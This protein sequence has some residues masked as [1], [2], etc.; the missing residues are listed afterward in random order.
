MINQ[1]Y[2]IFLLTTITANSQTK[3]YGIIKDH[4]GHVLTNATITLKG[5]Y[6]GAVSDPLGKYSFT[7]LEK[8]AYWIEAKSVGYRTETQ[9]II[10]PPKDLLQLNFTLK[11]EIT[12]L[13]AVMVTAGSFAAGDKKRASTVLSNLDILTTGGANGDIT[14]A[15]KTLPG[16]Q[17]IGEQE[18]LFVRGGAGYETKQFIDGTVVNNPYFTSITDIASRGRFSPNLFKGTIFSTGGYSALYGQALSSA[19]ILESIDLPEKSEANAS[20]SSVFIGGGFQQLAKNKRSSWGTNYGYINLLLYYGIVKQKFDNFIYPEY[21]T[22]DA[23]FRI[24]TKTGGM[25][26]YYTTFS[27]G[28]FGL[29]TPNIDSSDLNNA[30]EVKNINWYNNLSWR[31]YLGNGWKMNVGLNFSTNT[32]KITEQVENKN[33]TTVYTGKVYIDSLNFKLHNQQN[34]SQLKLVFEKKFSGLNAIRFGA[35]HWY[36]FNKSSINTPTAT[37]NYLLP[38]HFT[39]A[40]AETDLYVTNDIA[41]NSGIRAE[42]S[43]LINKFNVAPRVSFA[44]K[45]GKDAQMSFAYGIFYQKPELIELQFSTNLNYTKATHY[46]LNYQKINKDYTFRIEAYYK[47]YNDL[48][49]TYPTYNNS[50]NGYAQG[51]EL[52]WRDKKTFKGLDYWISYSYL[53]TKRNFQYYPTQLQPSFATPHTISIVTKKFITSIK[54]GFNFTYT[55]AT[56]RPYYFMYPNG[57]KYSIGDEGTTPSYNNLGF[58]LNYLPKLGKQKAKSFIVVVASITNALNSNQIYGYQYSYNGLKKQSI[59]PPA[60][61]FFFLGIFLSWGVDRT[62]DAINNNL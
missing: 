28:Y 33:N 61:Q 14:A 17:Q 21:H 52:F 30:F 23:N 16:A 32:D 36:A 7:T 18:G 34:L 4:K 31:E 19:L 38:D 60:Q 54:T 5:T 50:G 35:E 20:I 47:K 56:G 42:Y 53:D 48:V 39:A 13:K 1:I 6:D 15:V 12:E 8:G 37:F 49:K 11:E 62:Q 58:S 57:N 2:I 40:F 22:A 29:R 27:Y 24:K 41:I 26:K 44:Y 59:T 45:T 9:K 3:I 55:Y 43:S 25:I 46:I 51:I 10:L